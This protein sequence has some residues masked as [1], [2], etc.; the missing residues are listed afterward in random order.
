VYRVSGQTVLCYPLIFSASEFY[1]SH[2]LALL[3]DDI[4]AEIKFV[5]RRWRLAGREN[6]IFVKNPSSDDFG[7]KRAIH[8]F[9]FL[10]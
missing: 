4:R 5:S 9:K 1:L 10:I 2:D 3:I 8:W 7:E 6:L